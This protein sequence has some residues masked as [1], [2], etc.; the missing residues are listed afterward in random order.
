MSADPRAA[1]SALVAAFERHLEASASRRG[2]EDPTV[3]A[4]YEDL[5]DAFENYDDALL[6][7]YGE[8]TPLEVYSGA[9]VDEETDIEFEDL[10][11]LDD[12]GDEDG[13]DAG[14]YSGFDDGDYEEDE[15][16][17]DE[18]ATSRATRS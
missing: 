14:V 15:D 5:A 3:I 18:A 2:E 13:D 7:A 11:E 4:A 12:H 1:L 9:D 8:M 6:E 10:D 16:A 17:D